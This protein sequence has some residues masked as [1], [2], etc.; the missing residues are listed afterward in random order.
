MVPCNY[1]SQTTLRKGTDLVKKY[2]CPV[3]PYCGLVA[4][5]PG[6]AAECFVS[7]GACVAARLARRVGGV[8]RALRLFLPGHGGFGAG[9]PGAWACRRVITAVIWVARALPRQ[10]AQPSVLRA[11]VTGGR[12]RASV[13]CPQ[14]DRQRLPG[15]PAAVISEDSPRVVPIGLLPRRLRLLLLR[16][17]GHDL[18]SIWQ[19]VPVPSA[20]TGIF[21]LR[22]V[23]YM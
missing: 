5:W 11:P 19:P 9:Q 8:P 22:A 17:D 10:A 2:T 15:A 3:S 1:P 23:S 16:T 4:W 7:A 21:L 20:D 6:T 12:V 14:Q 18:A 13:A